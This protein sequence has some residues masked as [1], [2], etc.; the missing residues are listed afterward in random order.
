MF[1]FLI[2]P[3]IFFLLKNFAIKSD[4]DAFSYFSSLSAED[5][6]QRD[7]LVASVFF[8]LVT[9]VA[10]AIV[11]GA[12]CACLVVNHFYGTVV[13]PSIVYVLGYTSN[14]QDVLL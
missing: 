9:A 12:A 13:H 8:I 5:A 2:P 11:V 6:A 7:A 1:R 4:V 3:A 14:L 10:A